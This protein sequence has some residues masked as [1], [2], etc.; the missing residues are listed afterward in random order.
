MTKTATRQN[1]T[2]LERVKE[3]AYKDKESGYKHLDCCYD[4]TFLTSQSNK[5]MTELVLSSI[6]VVDSSRNW[7]LL[8]YKEALHIKRRKSSLNSGLNASSLESYNY[9]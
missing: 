5:K 3:H 9:I 6:K 8:L 4:R 7:N 2:I 1:R